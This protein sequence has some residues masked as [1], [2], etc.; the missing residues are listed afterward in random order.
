MKERNTY[1]RFIQNVYGWDELEKGSMKH[2]LHHC[3]EHDITTFDSSDFF[4]SNHI[5]K[6]FGTAL[7]E[8]GL[9]RDEIQLIAKFDDSSNKENIITTVEELLLTIKTDYLDLLLINAPEPSEDLV[10]NIKRLHSQGKILEIGGL[11][12]ETPQIIASDISLSA[13]Q[14][15]S[16]FISSEAIAA[17][18]SEHLKSEK[19]TSLA[20][21][22]FQRNKELENQTLY[23]ELSQKYNITREQLFF[24]W[25]LKHPAHLHPVINYSNKELITGATAAKEVDLTPF[26]WQKINLF[27]T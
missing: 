15:K 5:K 4:G 14:L 3:I 8:S 13:Y 17:L 26:D 18:N 7:S 11:T 23:N 12:L 9:S 19:I 6:R 20:W 2:L 22:D 10:Q 24:S 16:P 27:L 1:S 25:L 21:S